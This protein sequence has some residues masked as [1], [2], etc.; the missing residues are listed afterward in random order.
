MAGWGAQ[1][2][3]AVA[4]ALFFSPVVRGGGAGV[5]DTGDAGARRFQ[6]RR[7][8][9]S[10]AGLEAGA[11]MRAAILPVAPFR[12]WRHMH[13]QPSRSSGRN[14]SATESSRV[15]TLAGR[16]Q[17]P[18]CRG[19]EGR[20]CRRGLTGRYRRLLRRRLGGL[21]WRRDGEV[22]ITGFACCRDFRRGWLVWRGLDR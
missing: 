15:R 5:N 16:T 2:L 1:C 4:Q 3:F 21:L 12:A 11:D 8:G 22:S 19:R 20:S 10:W 7:D 17:P 9:R 6:N 13:V 18:R 14:I